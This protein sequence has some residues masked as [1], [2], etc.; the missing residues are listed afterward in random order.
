[1]RKFRGEK[2]ENSIKIETPN[3]YKKWSLAALVYH[4]GLTYAAYNVL[5]ISNRLAHSSTH[6]YFYNSAPRTFPSNF[7]PRI[8]KGI[9]LKFSLTQQW[10]F[11]MINYA[12]MN[13]LKKW[14]QSMVHWRWKS[15]FFPILNWILI[16]ILD[17]EREG[18]FLELKLFFSPS[19]QCNKR[20]KEYSHFSK[21]FFR[22]MDFPS[23]AIGRYNV[24][25]FVWT[26]RLD[27]NYFEK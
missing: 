3:I 5:Y 2:K 27:L 6:I 22:Q 13:L 16:S 26:F 7:I 11:V 20:R 8:A 18:T 4:S 10:V 21:P 25:A 9:L 15:N 23:I 14:H 19:L 1:M 17:R 12:Q 24:R